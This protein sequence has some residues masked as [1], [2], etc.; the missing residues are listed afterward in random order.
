MG[1]AM[2]IRKERCR[3]L[4]D[5]EVD[6]ALTDM[7]E[8][9]Q[10]GKIVMDEILNQLLTPEDCKVIDEEREDRFRKKPFNLFFFVNDEGVRDDDM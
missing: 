2:K 7:H 9:Q 10:A 5:E 4:T 8:E 6:K 3:K 1:L